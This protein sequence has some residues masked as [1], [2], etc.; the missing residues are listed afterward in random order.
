M[1]ALELQTNQCN[2]EFVLTLNYQQ[3]KFINS[4]LTGKSRTSSCKSVYRKRYTKESHKSFTKIQA[5]N[6]LKC[7]HLRLW[8]AFLRL[9][10]FHFF[11]SHYLATRS[12]TN[13][14]EMKS[15]IQKIENTNRSVGIEL[16]QLPILINQRSPVLL[17]LLSQVH[18]SLRTG[19]YNT[20][21]I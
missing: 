8:F 11:F 5:H 2:T 3:V 9:L 19:I 21:E 16:F 7:D 1:V 12:H 15:R 4:F 20:L 14:K 10:N 17:P 13:T 6:L 18:K